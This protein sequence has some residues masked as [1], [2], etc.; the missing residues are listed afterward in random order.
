[1]CGGTFHG[2]GGEEASP[3]QAATQLLAMPLQ[4]VAAQASNASGATQSLY[5]EQP[6]QPQQLPDGSAHGKQGDW[7][8]YIPTQYK[9]F[10]K[11]AAS[12][13]N[14]KEGSDASQASAFL[15]GS[16]VVVPLPSVVLFS[17]FGLSLALALAARGTRRSVTP[18]TE[19]LG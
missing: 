18:P 6:E 10:L 19:A 1:L 2:D 4:L 15:S 8:S 3:A 14:P 9:H 12:E 5:A 7:E 13:K 16:E 11:H 17:V